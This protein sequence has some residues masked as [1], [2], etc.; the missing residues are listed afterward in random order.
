V[1]DT[2]TTASV[3]ASELHD[4][5]PTTSSNAVV[6]PSALRMAPRFRESLM[7]PPIHHTDTK[8]A[9]QNHGQPG[10]KVPRTEPWRPDP[11]LSNTVLRQPGTPVVTFIA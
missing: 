9:N 4:A 11:E 5:I 10:T 1:I 2:D 8:V 7:N 3:S 6:N